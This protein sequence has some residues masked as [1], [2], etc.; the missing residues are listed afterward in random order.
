MEPKTNGFSHNLNKRKSATKIILFE[1][2]PDKTHSRIFSQ[3]N[4][5]LEHDLHLKSGNYDIIGNTGLV[6]GVT[7]ETAIVKATGTGKPYFRKCSMVPVSLSFKS[8]DTSN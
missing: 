1:H 5:A 7:T 2:K 3:Q 6:W 4:E 8:C